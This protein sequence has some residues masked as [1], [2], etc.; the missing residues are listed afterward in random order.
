MAPDR[1]SDEGPS[2]SRP[3][4]EGILRQVG[5]REK[6]EIGRKPISNFSLECPADREFE[7]VCRLMNGE[8]RPGYWPKESLINSGRIKCKVYTERS[9]QDGHDDLKLNAGAHAQ[10]RVGPRQELRRQ[11][12]D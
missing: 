10:A 4:E 12:L 2:L 3:G 7:V 6:F 11:I 8:R 5:A 9:V 1:D